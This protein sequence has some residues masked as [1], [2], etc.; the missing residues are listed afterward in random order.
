MLLGKGKEAGYIR[1]LNGNTEGLLSD[2]GVAGGAVDLADLR[3]A[4]QGIHN[5]VFP[6]TAAN[7]KNS[8]T[9]AV[10]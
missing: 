1:V 4:A 6:A 2:A 9:Q 7:Y 3:A 5:S 10:F 8:L